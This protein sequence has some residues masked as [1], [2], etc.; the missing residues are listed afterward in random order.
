MRAVLEA[1]NARDLEALLA[2]VTR[3]PLTTRAQTNLSRTRTSV[4]MRSGGSSR[5]IGTSF[6]EA[7]SGS[8]ADRRWR[9]CD[10]FDGASRGASRGKPSGAGVNDTYVF[11]YHCAMGWPSRAGLQDETGS[12]R[13]R[14]PVGARR[15]RR[16]LSLRDTA[17]AMS[18]ETI[19]RKPL[20][21]THSASRTLEER[22]MLRFPRLFGSGLVASST[23][24]AG[25]GLAF[26]R[27]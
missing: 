4:T 25:E 13:S 2:D 19:I 10:R 5:G 18:Q 9:P 20:S 3:N 11:I 24:S 27:R 15:S 21:A 7:R 14:R 1:W 22:L 6:S 17:R 12:P 23:S 8:R 16:L 26:G